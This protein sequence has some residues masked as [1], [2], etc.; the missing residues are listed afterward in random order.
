MV[1][2]VAWLHRLPLADVIITDDPP[3]HHEGIA[4]AVLELSPPPEQYEQ[5]IQIVVDFVQ[6]TLGFHVL[7]TSRHAS[8]F[9]YV[10]L[11]SVV[12]RDALVMGGPMWLMTNLC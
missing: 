3:K 11:A 6:N 12:L 10:H 1:I 9:A 7:D 4:V 2:S 5:F 8:E